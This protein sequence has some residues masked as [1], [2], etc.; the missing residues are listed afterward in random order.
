MKMIKKAKA[1]ITI[2]RPLN[3]VISFL[4]IIVIGIICIEGEY[5]TL[6]IFLA[7]L[8]G[9]FTG[10]AG[11]IINDIFDIEI[12]KIN[13]P[14][15]P[16]P[17]ELIT[18]IEAKFIYFILFFSSI[19]I[20]LFINNTALL[21]V[22]FANFM[23]FFYSYRL[24]KIPL[25]GN[26]VVAF[27]TGLA[28]IYGGIA[29]NNWSDVLFPALFAFVINFIREIVKDMED[30]EGD[31]LKNVFTFPA[32]YGNNYTLKLINVSTVLLVIAV[33]IPFITG[34]YGY[35]FMIIIMM[36]VIP[37]LFYFI[38]SLKKDLSKKNL[39]RM[40]FLLKLNMIFGLIAIYFG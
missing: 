36:T 24:K 9:A 27:V 25:A 37:S 2:L 40:S 1:Y 20:S 39:G 5:S 18:L 4:S 26:F 35:P 30:I 7:G 15:R 17:A 8:S 16:L 3:F 14:D 33:F 31:T 34:Y 28:F 38:F 23:V 32:K 11:N 6:K 12:D 22:L 10:S 21:I 29:V 19:I 13:R